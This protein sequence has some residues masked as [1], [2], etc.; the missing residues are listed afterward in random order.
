V[1]LKSVLWNVF[2]YYP[3]NLSVLW[4]DI[5]NATYYRIKYGFNPEETWDLSYHQVKWLLP[6]L[7]YF[8]KKCCTFPANLNSCEEW[9]AILDKIIQAF[10]IYLEEDPGDIDL[11][12]EEGL[13]LYRKYFFYL[14]W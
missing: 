12:V 1:S 14:W 3:S 2:N 11:R 6:R 10:S 13:D 4:R 9:E 7:K 5:L 8:R